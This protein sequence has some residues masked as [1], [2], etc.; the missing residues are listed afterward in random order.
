MSNIAVLLNSGGLDSLITAKTMKDLGWELHSLYIDLGQLNGNTAKQSAKRI[1]DKYCVSHEE[2]KIGNK[3]YNKVVK[4]NGADF[5][6]LP[7]QATLVHTVGGFY[8]GQ[9]EIEY[10][11]SGQKDDAVTSDFHPTLTKLFSSEILLNGII[12]LRPV[13]T[14]LHIE[15]VVAKGKELGLTME[16]MKQ[17]YSCN[18]LPRCGT[19]RKCLERKEVGLDG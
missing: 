2:L 15:N 11:V 1:A 3:C 7:M 5:L 18:A 16:E 13:S 4:V 17:T 6:G 9:N 12:F 10:V 8:A 14:L 19:C